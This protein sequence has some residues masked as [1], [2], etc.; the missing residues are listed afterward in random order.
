MSVSLLGPWES[1]RRRGQWI[2]G[3]ALR[4]GRP[5]HPTQCRAAACSPRFLQRRSAPAPL[6]TVTPRT[7]SALLCSPGP[8]S[9]PQDP[10]TSA[11]ARA[12]GS[13]APPSQETQLLP[14]ARWVLACWPRWEVG[15]PRFQG[16]VAEVRDRPPPS[17]ELVGSKGR[18]GQGG[19]E[20]LRLF[21]F[22]FLGNDRLSHL[23]RAWGAAALRASKSGAGSFAGAGG[24]KKVSPGGTRSKALALF[25]THMAQPPHPGHRRSA[26]CHEI[27]G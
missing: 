18:E 25:V 12:P 3:G 4:A 23:L 16:P 10:G 27:L 7:Q 17:D 20:S 19:Q 24:T 21:S 26:R 11:P 8:W 1:R 13:Q 14:L 15:A 5:A 6:G 2:H 9:P 22:Y